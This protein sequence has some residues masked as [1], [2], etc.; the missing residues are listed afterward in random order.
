MVQFRH[1]VLLLLAI[2]STSGSKAHTSKPS[3]SVDGPERTV[4]G[5]YG[6]VLVRAPSGLLDGANR[7]IF[8]PYLSRSLLLKMGTARICAQ[9]WFRQNRGQMIKAPFAWS[10]AG[11]FTGGNERTYPGT[12]RIE[13]TQA[14]KDGSFH[15]TV[16]FTYRASD[17][18]GSWRVVDTVV[19][20][21]GRFVVDEV[22]FPSERS[23]GAYTLSQTLSEGCKGPRWVG[24]Q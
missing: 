22:A 15:V 14:E 4:K 1:P 7:R 19:R 2:V 11:M 18:P 8:A 12:F 20:E 5:L 17:G 16:S 21:D 10:E 13:S 9:D 6:K 24:T 3:A 23:E